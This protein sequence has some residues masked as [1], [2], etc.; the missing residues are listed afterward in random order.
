MT[1]SQLAIVRLGL[2]LQ[3]ALLAGVILRRRYSACVAFLVYL[4]A[5]IVP[6][7]LFGFWPG[8][9]YTWDNYILNEI[10]H[11]LVKFAI[12]LELAY[13]TCRA[14][15]GAF[16]TARRVV[17]FAFLALAVVALGIQ[18]AGLQPSDVQLEW[19]ARVLN[20]TIWLFTALAA[21]ILW[22]R[23][24]V[25]AFHKAILVGFVPYLLVF[26]IGLRALAE[27]GEG[28]RLLQRVHTLG[29]LA[30]LGYWNRAAWARTSEPVRAREAVA[31]GQPEAA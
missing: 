25:H 16:L 20:G 15:P 5:T 3:V 31:R 28:A 30:L 4:V 6:A 17:L 21:V 9:F 23:I 14:F 22:Y 19:N 2:I 12:A 10:V 26:S 24:P 11:N 29:Y 8:R 27:W 13:R 18:T 1:A 7:F